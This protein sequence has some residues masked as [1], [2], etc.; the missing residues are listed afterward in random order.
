[1]QAQ[2]GPA[3]CDV[4]AVELLSFDKVVAAAGVT[5]PDGLAFDLNHVCG[6]EP[7]TARFR[8]GFLRVEDAAGWVCDPCTYL[9]CGDRGGYRKVLSLTQAYRAG[10]PVPPIV[11]G[12][13]AGERPSLQILDGLHRLNAAAAA[14]LAALAA[15]ETVTSGE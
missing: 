15:Y 14:G 3:R 8:L 10:R 12:W 5:D 2:R 13:L 7:A 9:T 6:L 11:Y 1:M 4:V